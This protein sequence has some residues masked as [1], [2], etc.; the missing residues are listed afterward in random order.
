MQVTLTV[1]GGPNRDLTFT[2]D[3]HATFLVGRSPEAHFIIPE[4]TDPYFSRHHFMIEINPPLCRLVDLNSKNGTYVNGAKVQ[5]IDLKDGDEIRGGFTTIRVAIHA[6]TKSSQPPRTE[7]SNLEIATTMPRLA[8]LAL[9]WNRLSGSALL[10]NIRAD[11]QQRWAGGERLPVETYLELAP[12]LHRDVDVLLDLIYS[13]ILLREEQGEKPQRDEYVRRFPQLAQ[14]LQ[15]QFEVH[16]AVQEEVGTREQTHQLKERTGR[17]SER[18]G[19]TL[20]QPSQGNTLAYRLPC[21]AGYED[22]QQIGHGN[23]G[24]VYQAHCQLEGVRVAIKTVVPVGEPSPALLTDFFRSA[25][26]LRYLRHSSIVSLHELGYADDVLYFVLDYVSGIS[27]EAALKREGAWPLERSVTLICHLLEALAYAHGQ[28]F[29]HGDLKPTN[30]LLTSASAASV[31]PTSVKI[32]DFG[33]ARVYQAS[34]LSGLTMTARSS[35]TTGFLPPEQV[36][37]VR[38]VS[39]AAD[40]YAAAATLYTMLTRQPLYEGGTN[41]V[42]MMKRLLREEPVP[43]LTRRPDLPTG[44]AQAVQKALS[45]KPERRFADVTAFQAALLPFASP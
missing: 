29:V 39:A 12:V 7:E 35:S 25:N 15:A 21:I 27:L 13:E 14:P 23:L 26:P 20:P 42:E 3:Q 38:A 43:L 10:E 4:A 28:G 5:T 6:P 2:F 8:E 17:T 18:R 41:P 22:L 11:Q 24:V 31:S 9:R 45:R 40:Q 19:Q 36:L 33:L 44:L 37:D 16:Q 30:V 32:T 1:T 34:P